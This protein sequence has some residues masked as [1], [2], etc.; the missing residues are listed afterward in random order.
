MGSVSEQ[1][2]VGRALGDRQ[3]GDASLRIAV[4]DL[5]AASLAALM[6]GTGALLAALREGQQP[7][8]L[9]TWRIA[10]SKP[11]TIETSGRPSWASACSAQNL[12]AIQHLHAAQ[13]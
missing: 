9:G 2:D 4:T 8:P 1:A 7:E 6:R 5:L 3:V 11:N 13:G 10:A 12:A